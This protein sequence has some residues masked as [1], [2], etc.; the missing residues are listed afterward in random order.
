MSPKSSLLSQLTLI[1]LV[2][3]ALLMGAAAFAS[4]RLWSVVQEFSHL[5]ETEQRWAQDIGNIHV[6][7]KTQIQEWKNVLLRS[8]DAAQ[9]DKYWASFQK[10]EQQVQSASTRLAESMADPTARQRVQGFV[11]A[12]QKMGEDYRKGLAALK[13]AGNDH[14]AGDLAVK[15]MDREPSELLKQVSELLEKQAVTAAQTAEADAIRAL[16][17]AGLAM[18]LGLVAGLFCF[19][20]YVHAHVVSR[21][22]H[23][24]MGLS[25]LEQGEFTQTIQAGRGDEIGQI[26]ASADQVR[27]NLGGLIGGIAKASQSVAQTS[28]QLSRSTQTLAESAGKQSETV[29]KNV[30]SVEEMVASITSI[31]GQTDRINETFAEGTE[32]L[33]ASLTEVS[34]L[35]QQAQMLGQVMRNIEVS[36][37]A[38][39]Q[40]TAAINQ[41]TAQVKEIAEQT[42]L[43][44]LNAAIEAARAGEQGRG[45]AV[46]ADEVRKLAEN[47]AKAAAEIKS[48]TGQL[49]AGADTVGDAVREGLQV[50]QT[51]Q[52]AVGSVIGHIQLAHGCMQD[53]Q[54][55]V[56]QIRSAMS[57]QKT[58]CSGLA[59]RFEAI[60]QMVEENA[61]ATTQIKQASEG[62]SSLAET[63]RLG[64][65]RFKV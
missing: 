16:W 63:M 48:V 47:S 2:V 28:S 37:T 65:T 14:K 8:H 1:V 51:S 24:V 20:M 17:W 26:A 42:N 3:I 6:D 62:L 9:G 5:V 11:K 41:L 61:V 22:R 59:G 43:L 36:S 53:V 4:Y 46:V 45:F 44:A 34:G 13:A 29:T 56:Q 57:E 52:A 18:L 31:A 58:V 39:L 64:V 60:A 10:H 19:M 38:F 15:G 49:S 21:A 55:G 32:K 12:H 23:L 35:Q 27:S 33:Q 54:G 7:F 40:S 50:A 30:A 25:R